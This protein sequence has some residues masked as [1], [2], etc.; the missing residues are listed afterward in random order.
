MFAIIAQSVQE[1]M[2]TPRNDKTIRMNE[3][4][5]EKEV[6]RLTQSFFK[7]RGQ[8]Y[9]LRNPSECVNYHR[10]SYMVI[11]LKVNTAHIAFAWPHECVARMTNE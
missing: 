7:R 4:V 5:E 8:L 2:T 6:Q 1:A 9:H 11:V 10:T 3:K